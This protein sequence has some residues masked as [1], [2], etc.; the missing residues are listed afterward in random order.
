VSRLGV[1]L[2]LGG[3]VLAVWIVARQ[4]LSAVSALLAAGGTATAGAR[5]VGSRRR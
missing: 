3:L 5:A 2:A 1:L 4:D